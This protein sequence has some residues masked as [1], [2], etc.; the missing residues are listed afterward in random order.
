MKILVGAKQVQAA[1]KLDPEAGPIAAN[2]YRDIG[3]YIEGNFMVPAGISEDKKAEAKLVKIWDDLLKL[4][5]D[6]RK[7]VEKITHKTW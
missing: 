6:T 5:Q 4:A 2:F 1:K 3:D 7:K